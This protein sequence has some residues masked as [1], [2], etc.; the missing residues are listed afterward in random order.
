MIESLLSQYSK[1]QLQAVVK[2]STNIKEAL[3]KLGYQYTR[4]TTYELFK[5]ICKQKNIDYSHFTG[6]SKDEIVRT[7]QNIFCKDSTAPQAT[8]RNW[9]LKGKYS[10]YKCAI[11]GISTWRNQKLTLRLDHINGDNHDDRL[12]NLRWVCPNCDSQLETFCRGHKRLVKKVNV[13][14]K[15]G[16]PISNGAKLCR[17]CYKIDKQKTERPDRET[18][19]EL[20]RT[21][22]FLQ[23]GKDYNVSDNAIRKWCDNYNLPRTKKEINSYSNQEWENI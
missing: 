5:R 10:E 22:S 19:K 20:I 12:E 18:L 13:C 16:T 17:Q 6:R 11:C 2:N 4:G 3:T 8:L 23:I 21:T 9:Y 15:C 14:L 7:Q 1:E